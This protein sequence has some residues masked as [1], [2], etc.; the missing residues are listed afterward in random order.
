VPVGPFL[1]STPSQGVSERLV[2]FVDGASGLQKKPI[3]Y[4]TSAHDTSA[5]KSSG[6]TDG[7]AVSAAEAEAL[8]GSMLSERGA[9]VVR[10]FS[11]DG[12]SGSHK[13]FAPFGIST[14]GRNLIR[15]PLSD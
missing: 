5:G 1:R 13:I 12:A 9:A 10:G 11:A 7:A 15:R 4:G 2:V 3:P 6:D 14:H 8:S